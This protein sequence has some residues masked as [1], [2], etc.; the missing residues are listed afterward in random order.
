MG[1][2]R[3]VTA[4]ASSSRVSGPHWIQNLSRCRITSSAAPIPTTP[5]KAKAV[6][7]WSG[8][9]MTARQTTRPGFKTVARWDQVPARLLRAKF[10]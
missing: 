1:A 4:G 9:V 8:F 5:T 7:V 2:G 6:S 10:V 3:E